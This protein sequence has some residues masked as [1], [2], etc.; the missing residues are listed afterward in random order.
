MNASTGELLFFNSFDGQ[1]IPSLRLIHKCIESIRNYRFYS[2]KLDPDIMTRYQ[3][4]KGAI[5]FVLNGADIMCPGLTSTG[6]KMDVD[7]PAGS[8]VVI[9][10]E[11]KEHAMS[12]GTLKIS[13]E[14]M[15]VF[16]IISSNNDLFHNLRR[17]INKGIA[18]ETLH[19]LN[20]NFWKN[21]ILS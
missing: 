8:L 20:D 3:V 13:T 15:Y 19:Y 11:G 7:L 16:D 2:Y 9:T 21:H 17:S 4:D 12:I 14:E 18:I 10:A 5:K 1:W 6:A